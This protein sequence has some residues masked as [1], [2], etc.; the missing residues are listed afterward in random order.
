MSGS[1]RKTTQIEVG[2]V[3]LEAE[4]RGAGKPLLLLTGEEQLEVDAAFVEELA[5]THEV[6]I[7][8]PPGFGHSER[9]DWITSPD[10][11]AY[12]YLDLIKTLGLTNVT[13]VGFSLGGWIA[14][15]MATKN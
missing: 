3:K 2:G 8:S 7:P 12:L 11:I 4:R 13:V 6:I 5:R 9:P 15:E 10:D 1:E 14:A